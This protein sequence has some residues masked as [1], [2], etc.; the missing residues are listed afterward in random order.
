M[1]REPS[2]LTPQ[3]ARAVATRGVSVVLSSGAGCGKTHVLT[4]RYLSHLRHDGAEVGQVVAITFTDRAA[5]QMRGRIRQALIE[6]LRQAPDDHQADTWA[7]HLRDLENAPISTIHAFCATLLRQH[8][9]EAGLDPA[10]DVLEE[11]LAVNL[12]NEALLACLQRLLLAGGQEGED[13]RELVLLFGWRGVVEAVEHLMHAWDERPWQSWLDRPAGAVAEDWLRFA[14][15]VVLPRHLAHAVATRPAI[16]RTLDLLRRHPPL[17]GPMSEAADTLL[18]E[19]P[20]LTGTADL[21]AAVERLVQAAKVGRAGSKAWPDPAVYEAIKKAFE[22]FRAELRGLNLERFDA[23]AA[24]LEQAAAVGQRFLR[25][26]RAAVLAYRD[27][28]R[29]IGV[30][31]F[32]DLLVL[33]RDLLRDNASVRARLQDRYRFLL[34]DE[35]QDTD[36]VQME[37]VEGLAGAGLT[38][39]K[40]F[41]VGDW[42]QSIYRFRGA[43]VSLFQGLRRRVPLEG[44]QGLTVNFRSQP[45]ILDFAN[46]LLGQALEEYEA[47][48]PHQAQ[49][50]PGPCIEFLWSP[51][52]EDTSVAQARAVEADWIARRLAAM[53]GREELVAGEGT[54][55]PRPV[56]AGDVV[57]LFRA[58]SNVHLYESALRRRGLDYYLVGGR[59]FF[60]QQEVYDLL[61]LLRALEN[62]HDGLSLAGAL[63]SPFCCLSDEALF[64]LGRHRAGLWAALNAEASEAILPRDQLERVRRARRNLSAWRERKDLLPI[65]RLVETVIAE[66]GYDAA[67]GLE[68]LGERNLANLWKL[69]ELARTFDR[70]G[71]FGLAE[72]IAR[73]GDFVASQPREEQAATQPENADVV[74]LMTIHQAKGL[75][76]PVVFIPDVAAE[77]GSASQ[78]TAAWDPR[79]GCVVRPPADEEPAPFPEMPWRLRQ[80]MGELEEWAEDLRTL[81][82]ACTRPRD[83]LVLSAA[84]PE[85]VGPASRAGPGDASTDRTPVPLGSRHLPVVGPASRAGPGRS[86]PRLGAPTGSAALPEGYQAAGPWMVTLARRFD[87]ATGA[88]LADDI[89]PERRPA[90]RVSDASCPPDVPAVREA[91]RG[92][93]APPPP[94]PVLVP[95]RGNDPVSVAEVQQWLARAD[96]LFAGQEPISDPASRLLRRV[97]LRWDFR[98]ADGWREPLH[99]LAEREG[100]AG[101]EQRLG[102]VLQRLATTDVISRLAKARRVRRNVEYVHGAGEGPTVWGQV[103]CLYEDEAGKWDVVFWETEPVAAAAREECWNRRL[104]EMVL[105]AA[106]LRE[107]MGA[108][109][110]GVALVLVREGEALVRPAVRLPHQRVLQ[111]VREALRGVAARRVADRMVV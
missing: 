75:E 78:P 81:Y 13:L 26:A 73:L 47:L 102:E 107:Q 106:A 63:R 46:A 72:F 8:A 80:A 56:R 76:F 109:P 17:P 97:L 110:G 52:P 85:A 32:Q 71:L 94:L 15:E 5:R 91:G 68:F 82:V 111:R 11:V 90:V 45:A 36:P 86:A 54:G 104:T 30:V 25:V 44:R 87:L 34:I 53:I 48:T 20:A 88:C 40:L 28:K 9:V 39:G 7:R 12:R 42:K 29:A 55:K 99:R 4:E 95:V 16:V 62:P 23:D 31:D 61:N 58:M 98:Q 101:E 41:A 1:T 35:L 33:A 77:P 50:S 18:R 43:D 2:S 24:E 57:L 83:Y 105:A 89:S 27:R 19:V 70:T 100:L 67:V 103:D 3:Q 84:L 93:M 60:A 38:T 21:P 108:W 49:V 37:L 96:S 64:V 65:A 51:R 74:R 14:R 22:A 79:L 66:S 10:F 69:V 59:A 6:H 92:R